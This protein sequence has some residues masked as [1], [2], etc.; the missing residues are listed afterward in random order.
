ML[1]NFKDSKHKNHVRVSL[2]GPHIVTKSFSHSLCWFERIVEVVF[3]PGGRGGTVC[4]L[5]SGKGKE[6]EFS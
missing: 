6:T 2:G 5:K 4:K 1:S 3:G